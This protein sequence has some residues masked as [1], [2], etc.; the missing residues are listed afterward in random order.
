ME[1]GQGY[2]VA[3]TPVAE[4]YY[5]DV[6]EYFY[7]HHSEGSADRKSAELLEMAIGLEMNPFLGRIEEKLSSFGRKH[8]YILY[9][10]TKRKAIKIIYF[11]NEQEKTVYITD[12]FPCE[13]DEGKIISGKPIPPLAKS[14]FI[15]TSLTYGPLRLPLRPWR[16]SG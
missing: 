13:N 16:L 12:F 9:F 4:N 5:R 7:K 15:C 1:R 14:C 3:I 2:T 11:I 10:Y 8:R 6:L